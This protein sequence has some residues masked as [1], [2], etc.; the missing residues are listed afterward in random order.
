MLHA[1]FKDNKTITSGEDFIY[2]LLYIGMVAI[3]LM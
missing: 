1:N 3:L 2:F